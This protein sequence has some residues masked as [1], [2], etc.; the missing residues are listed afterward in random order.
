M[1]GTPAIIKNER[2]ADI[3]TPRKSRSF[4]VSRCPGNLQMHIILIEGFKMSFFHWEHHGNGEFVKLTQ[5]WLTCKKGFNKELSISGWP[6]HMSGRA[7]H[8]AVV[9]WPI[10]FWAAW[11]SL[12][13]FSLDGQLLQVLDTFTFSSHSEGLL[14]GMVRQINCLSLCLLL[15][16][17]FFFVFLHVMTFYIIVENDKEFFT[18]FSIPGAF[19]R[20]KLFNELIGKMQLI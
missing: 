1:Q 7:F 17:F 6:S 12:A 10:L 16:G 2:L 11:I 19:S 8:W 3:K 4:E 9:E 18:I 14:P 5:S 15:S 13:G 20:R